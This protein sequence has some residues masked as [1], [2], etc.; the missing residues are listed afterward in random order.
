MYSTVIN[1]SHWEERKDRSEQSKVL[2]GVKL[3]NHKKISYH[4]NILKMNQS[5][6][7]YW[8]VKKS[9]DHKNMY[10]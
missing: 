2:T 6:E 3:I 4:K 8:L 5:E 7:Y 10:Y 1:V 9:L